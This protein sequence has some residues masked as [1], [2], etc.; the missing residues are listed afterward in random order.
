MPTKSLTARPLNFDNPE[1][2]EA[3]EKARTYFNRT[4]ILSERTPSEFN[5]TSD[6]GESFSNKLRYLSCTEFSD[7]KQYTAAQLKYGLIRN[8]SKEGLLKRGPNPTYQELAEAMSSASKS[9]ELPVYSFIFDNNRKVSRA[10]IDS[11]TAAELY[12]ELTSFKKFYFFV[13]NY[14]P[15]RLPVHNLRISQVDLELIHSSLNEIDKLIALGVLHNPHNEGTNVLSFINATLSTES[16]KK[17]NVGHS[18][19]NTLA[20]SVVELQPHYS[21]LKNLENIPSN[22]RAARYLIFFSKEAEKA[23][24]TRTIA[25]M[26]S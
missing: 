14:Y 11:R 4:L 2:M 19:I 26:N 17:S 6:H 9:T 5:E 23:A 10:L 24:S 3:I 20:Q 1:T 21:I 15:Y 18:L 12:V 25:A 8:S 7:T 13:R 22:E 16:V